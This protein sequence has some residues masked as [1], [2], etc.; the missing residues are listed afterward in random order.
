MLNVNEIIFLCP[1]ITMFGANCFP[2]ASQLAK[3]IMIIGY[4]LKVII[5]YFV[6]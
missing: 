2:A 3:S 5:K 6:I 1:Y 4:M